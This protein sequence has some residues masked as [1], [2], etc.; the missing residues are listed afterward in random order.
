MPKENI[1]VQADRDIEK[2]SQTMSNADL[3]AGSL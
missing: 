1:P 3:K 2:F